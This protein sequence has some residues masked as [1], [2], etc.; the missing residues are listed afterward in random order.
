L[1]LFIFTVFT[2]VTVLLTLSVY[3]IIINEKLPT[4]DEVPLIGSYLLHI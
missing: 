3:Q 2:G 4:S 1:N